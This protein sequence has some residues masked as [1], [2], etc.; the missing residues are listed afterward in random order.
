M[1]A[2]SDYLFKRCVQRVE[3]KRTML[4]SRGESTLFH[5]FDSARYA[6]DATF[7]QSSRP[8]GNISED[9]AY[10]SGKHKLY[11]YRVEVFVLPSGLRIG[12]TAHHPGSVADLDIFRKNEA[13]HEEASERII[14][15]V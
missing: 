12:C 10:F 3:K 14:R 2:I 9:K 1:K 6:A 7:Q 15:D 11:G 8:T 4:Q 5:S 13:F